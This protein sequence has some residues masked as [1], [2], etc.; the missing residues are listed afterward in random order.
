[1]VAGRQRWYAEPPHMQAALVLLPD[2]VVPPAIGDRVRV[3][4]RM[5]ATSFDTVEGL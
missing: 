2:D 3:D 4:V 1:V 5:T